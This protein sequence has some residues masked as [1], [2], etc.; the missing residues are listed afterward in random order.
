[1]QS[2][3]IRRAFRDYFV[4]QTPETLLSRKWNKAVT[5]EQFTSVLCKIQQKL[6]HH[7]DVMTQLSRNLHLECIL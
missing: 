1:M 5:P 6:P 7:S 3:E 2:D 4:V